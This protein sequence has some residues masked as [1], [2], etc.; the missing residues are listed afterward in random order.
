MVGTKLRSSARRMSGVRGIAVDVHVRGIPAGAVHVDEAAQADRQDRV[1]GHLRSR[2]TGTYSSPR[3]TRSRYTGREVEREIARDQ[4]V[5]LVA[6][7]VGREARREEGLVSSP[8]ETRAATAPR[9]SSATRTRTVAAAAVPRPAPI[10]QARPTPGLL[11][12]LPS[13]SPLA[14]SVARIRDRSVGPVRRIIAGVLRTR[15]AN[16]GRPDGANAVSTPG[17]TPDSD[18]RPADDPGAGPNPLDADDPDD[19]PLAASSWLGAI[20][21]MTTAVIVVVAVVVLFIAAAVAL[22]RLLS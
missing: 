15:P 14:Q 16:A 19:A 9:A 3:S 2:S 20:G 6:P 22:R 10:R 8:Q 5:P 21:Q 11:W 18:D 1:A 17:V 13:L 12:T 4:E 7:R